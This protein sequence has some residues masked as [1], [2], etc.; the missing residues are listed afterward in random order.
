MQ[1]VRLG[2]PPSESAEAKT[3]RHLLVSSRVLSPAP[4]QLA[5]D[6]AAFP[7]PLRA[8]G[9]P[10]QTGSARICSGQSCLLWSCL[11]LGP[12]PQG[13]GDIAF[14]LLSAWLLHALWFPLGSSVVGTVGPVLGAELHLWESLGSADSLQPPPRPWSLDS[15]GVGRGLSSS[16]HCLYLGLFSVS[17]RPDPP[18]REPEGSSS[19]QMGKLRAKTGRNLS[20]APPCL[21]QGWD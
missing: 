5:G 10:V 3:E 2:A 19:S 8:P 18:A 1:K 20:T 9:R 15:H 17:R 11:R 6:R 4:L 14:C 16:S 12:R 13:P 7:T 21:Q